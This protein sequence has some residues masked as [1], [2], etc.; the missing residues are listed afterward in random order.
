MN[1][2]KEF[3][4]KLPMKYQRILSYP[5]WKKAEYN[6][7]LYVEDKIKQFNRE[8]NMS[9]DE[10]EQIQFSLFKKLIEY[11]YNHVEYYRTTWNKCG[12]KPENINEYSDLV[13]LPT[14]SKRIVIE[15]KERFLSDEVNVEDLIETSTGGSTGI[16]FHFYFN[17][18]AE[19][20]RK[21]VIDRWRFV[22]G[23]F[24][25]RVKNV[26]IGK[27]YPYLTEDKGKW[28]ERG[29]KFEGSFSIRNDVMTFS[30]MNMFPE[31][32]DKYIKN[33]QWY[34]PSFVQG[35]SSAVSAL[36]EYMVYKGISIPM[37]AV[38]TGS[39]ELTIERRKAIEKAFCCEVFN[40]YGMNEET[41]S[42]CECNK[43]HSAM[44]I[45]MTNCVMEVV[46]SAGRHIFDEKGS[47]IGT[48]LQN[49]AMPLIRY[50]TGDKGSISKK[51]C[52]CGWNSW[53]LDQFDGRSADVMKMHDGRVMDHPTFSSLMHEIPKDDEMFMSQ[54]EDYQMHQI[55]NDNII[56]SIIMKDRKR[57]S[58]KEIERC[59]KIIRHILYDDELMKITLNQPDYIV[60]GG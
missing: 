44:H 21:E 40:E 16:P 45:M 22:A 5:L 50:D 4:V 36:A 25:K 55:D 2:L 10:L 9:R 30:S 35:Y 18:S 41:C 23:V 11:A 3:F 39:D 27:S 54:I 43:N 60:G 19:N 24:G 38:L 51:I 15:N 48:N 8:M 34:Q 26:W 7:K 46:N 32:M 28:G 20:S 12:V 42:A 57:M 29:E 37:K 52:T 33:L 17:Q 1:I 59:V 49:F 56:L 13:L 58:P 6:N 14:I 53:M 47:I 31:A